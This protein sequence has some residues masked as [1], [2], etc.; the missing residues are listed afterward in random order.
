[1]L[2]SDKKDGNNYWSKERRFESFRNATESQ[3][4]IRKISFFLLFS[5]TPKQDFGA[6]CVIKYLLKVNEKNVTIISIT[7]LYL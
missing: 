2:F 6:K 5:A 3:D 1:M 7:K 4:Q